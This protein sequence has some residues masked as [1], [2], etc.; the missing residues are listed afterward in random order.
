MIFL[1]DYDRNSSSLLSI[2]QFDDQFRVDAEAARVKLEIALLRDGISRE[3]VLLEARNEIQ[4]R[5]T[6]RRYFETIEQLSKLP[7]SIWNNAA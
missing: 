4:L 5:K 1:V 3:V 6:H 7:D 2:T